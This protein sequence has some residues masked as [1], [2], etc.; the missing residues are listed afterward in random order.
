[1]GREEVMA[2]YQNE[3][4]GYQLNYPPEEAVVIIRDQTKST[5]WKRLFILLENLFM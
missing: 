1:M 3:F 4:K 5:F 2:Y